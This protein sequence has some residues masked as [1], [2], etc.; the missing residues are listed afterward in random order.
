MQIYEGKND[1]GL[2]IQEGKVSQR[3]NEIALF[4]SKARVI[5]DIIQEPIQPGTFFV[6]VTVTERDG[7][8]TVKDGL[9][10]VT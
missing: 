6:K 2:K 4:L 8:K 5:N 9:V 10:E 1:K 7:S 3:T